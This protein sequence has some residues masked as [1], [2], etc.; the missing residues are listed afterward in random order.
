MAGI[1]H[2]SASLTRLDDASHV[3]VQLIR[4]GEQGDFLQRFGDLGGDEFQ[5]TGET[6]TQRLLLFNG[7]MISERLGQNGLPLNSVVEIAAHSP[8]PETVVRTV[9]RVVLTREP[10][11][12][13]M[14]CY[15]PLVE[16]NRREAVEDMF[17]VLVN[18]SESLVNH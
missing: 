18:S 9:Y 1:V 15:K 17:W 11:K 6:V 2:Q 13:E 4:F 16:E 5:R 7:K 12:A 10:T 8:D 14:D 3:L